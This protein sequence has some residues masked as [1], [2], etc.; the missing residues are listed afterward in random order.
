MNK[1]RQNLDTVAKDSI[2]ANFK[3]IVQ[4]GNTFLLTVLAWI[5]FRAENV[6]HAIQYIKDIFNMSLFSRP[7][8]FPTI[9]LSFV[10]LLVVVEWLQRD[11]EHGLEF[12]AEETFLT[13]PVRWVVYTGIII[14]IFSFGGAQQEFIYFQF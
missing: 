9:V 13:K 6:G 5:F 2:Y 14:S 8:V 4:I 1:N 3:E 12:K 10:A 7:E 11:K